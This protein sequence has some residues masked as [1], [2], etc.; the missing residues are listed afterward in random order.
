MFYFPIVPRSSV[1]EDLVIDQSIK[2]ATRK[3]AARRQVSFQK[4]RHQ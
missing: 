3:V 2:I 1:K 4:A